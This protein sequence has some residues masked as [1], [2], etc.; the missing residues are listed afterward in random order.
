MPRNFNCIV[1]N[2]GPQFS[3]FSL[4]WRL[5]H[6]FICAEDLTSVKYVTIV[7]HFI[8]DE[9]SEFLLF[10]SFMFQCYLTWPVMLNHRCLD[11]NFLCL[12]SWLFKTGACPGPEFR[13]DIIDDDIIELWSSWLI[14]TWKSQPL[15]MVDSQRFPKTSSNC[16]HFLFQVFT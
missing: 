5:M 4:V 8:V 2:F 15:I 12:S 1:L 14:S 6:L 9:E 16:C 7:I 3:Q 11:L 13:G 10:V